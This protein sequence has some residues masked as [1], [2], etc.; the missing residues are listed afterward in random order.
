M[1][2][3]K[4]ISLC[5]AALL[6]A[7]PAIAVPPPPP[8]PGTLGA[9]QAMIAALKR[10]DLAAYEAVLTDDFVGHGAENDEPFNREAWL[11]KTKEA[12][13]NEALHIS[14]L[15]VF[16]GGATIEGKFRQQVMLVEHVSNFPLRDG[17]PG[18]CCTYYLTETLTLKGNK[19]G[20][21]DRSTVYWNALSKAGERTDLR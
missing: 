15:H 7:A 16:E 5:M 4:A 13:E 1:K 18:D 11:R 8:M 14:I 3:I 17:I 12:F 2:P 10:K 20:R 21:I 6:I 9:V 19:I